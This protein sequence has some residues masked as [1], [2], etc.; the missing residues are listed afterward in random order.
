MQYVG[1]D[2]SSC[3]AYDDVIALCNDDAGSRFQLQPC[4]KKGSAVQ[5]FYLSQY[6]SIADSLLPSLRR[7]GHTFNLLFK[8]RAVTSILA[9]DTE[10]DMI[11]GGITFRL[12]RL[13][14]H[15]AIVVNVIMVS[16]LQ[17]AGLSQQGTGTRLVAA[18][19]RC[20]MLVKQVC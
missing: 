6:K 17:E 15:N 14:G 10:N 19:T 13:R 7:R 16:V 1:L 3:F 20:A 5:V 12:T 4:W 9:L 2:D 18:A 8:E 11:V